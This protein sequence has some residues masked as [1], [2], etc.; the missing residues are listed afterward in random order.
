MT[1]V[2]EP[3]FDRRSS[4]WAIDEWDEVG[5]VPAVEQLPR[6]SRLVK[7]VVWGLLAIV[8]VLILIA[9]W[10]GWWYVERAKPEGE[11]SEPVPFT[12]LAGDT[13]ESIAAPRETEGIDTDA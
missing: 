10:V 7:W 2:G 8:V 11:I 9:G 4:D 3:G 5:E 13:V 1:V 12:V 6:Q